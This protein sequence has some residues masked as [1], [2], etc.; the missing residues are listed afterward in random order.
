VLAIVFLILF[1][2]H[3]AWYFAWLI[4]LTCVY[5]RAAA[6]YLTCAVGY[7]H[8]SNNW[9]PGLVDG[10]VIY[11]GFALVLLAESAVQRLSK[12]EAA[13]GDTVPA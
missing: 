2:P 9:P 6:I 13:H 7:L 4:P 12:K 3:Y 11:G 1:S 5:P 10:L 8:V